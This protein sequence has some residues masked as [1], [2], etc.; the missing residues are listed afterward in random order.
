MIASWIVQG[1]VAVWLIKSTAL[2]LLAWGATFAARKLRA[3][4]ALRHLLWLLAIVAVVALPIAS[5]LTPVKV[6]VLPA[7]VE[8]A[9]IAAMNSDAPAA[10]TLIDGLFG[11]YVVVAIA[12]LLRLVVGQVLL[13]LM[14]ARAERVRSI[15]S[16]AA[17]VADALGL[18]T[19]VA[20]RVSDIASAPMTWG[21]AFPKIVLPV[22][23]LQWAP[24]QRRLVLMHELVHVARA[25]SATQMFA[26]LTLAFGWFHPGLWLAAA[27][28]RREQEHACDER[29]LLSG[30]AA[31]EYAHTLLE[32]AARAPAAVGAV[33]VP[34][35]ARSQL[36]AR[37]AEIIRQTPRSLGFGGVIVTTGVALAALGVAATLAYASPVVQA[38]PVSELA[39]SAAPADAE[40][41]G[42]EGDVEVV[43]DNLAGEQARHV[44]RAS[45]TSFSP[46]PAIPAV[47]A[48]PAVPAI[49][50]VPATPAV[51]PSAEFHSPV[52]PRRA[53]PASI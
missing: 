43:L 31:N 33:A 12:L 14:W 30:A 49:P 40:P 32:V 50:P 35:A 34:M 42:D 47:P 48:V 13:S 53:K 2:I 38:G 44:H 25:D 11:L 9:P 1:A 23:A 20:I 24:E 18:Q 4:A 27:H 5:A 19:Q 36:E 6:A 28:L 41:L 7:P 15:E 52:C 46:V 3:P 26:S 51:I 22:N 37:L 17:L 39:A 16:E 10:W 29:V 45:L 8:A 21:A